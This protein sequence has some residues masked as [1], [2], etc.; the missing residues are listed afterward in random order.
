MTD[1]D[2]PAKW[3]ERV[4]KLENEGVTEQATSIN[5]LKSARRTQHAW[6]SMALSGTGSKTRALRSNGLTARVI[7]GM[8]KDT[9]AFKSNLSVL[10]DG[11]K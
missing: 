1:K 4:S 6:Y 3:G 5:I 7:G 8:I 11:L 10:S 9:T 2:E